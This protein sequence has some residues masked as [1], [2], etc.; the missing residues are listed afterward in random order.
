[1]SFEQ[2]I[3]LILSTAGSVGGAIWAVARFIIPKIVDAKI[4]AT[5]DEREYRQEREEREWEIGAQTRATRELRQI[6]VENQALNIARENIEW[7]RADFSLM[8]KTMEQQVRVLEQIREQ[9]RILA[10]E[11][12]RLADGLKRQ[13]D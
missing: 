8:Q 2:W 11:V 9:L 13:D 3:L 10:G 6:Q 5:D 7:A 12:A 1:V 4:K